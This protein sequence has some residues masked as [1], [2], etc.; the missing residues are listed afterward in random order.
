MRL[1]NENMNGDEREMNKITEKI[2]P[3]CKSVFKEGDEI[4][5]CSV[6]EMPHHK[7]CWIENQ[8]CATF[9]CNGT[10]DAP[11]FQPSGDAS[12]KTDFDAAEYIYCTKC[13]AQKFASDSFCYKCGHSIIQAP[14]RQTTRPQYAQTSDSNPYNQSQ[15]SYYSQHG[16]KSYGG[17]SNNYGYNQAGSFD[18]ELELLV[19]KNADYYVPKFIVMK[20]QNRKASW[21]WCSFL[22][23]PYWMIY[24]KMYGY[25]IA[26]LGGVF[27]VN[28]IKSWF[29]SFLLFIL[30]I[31]F[32]ILGNNIYMKYLEQKAEQ[33]RTLTGQYKT[34]FAAKNGGTNTSAVVLAILCFSILLT[35]FQLA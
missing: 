3:Y 33:M 16:D 25:G 20:T 1:F 17:Q 32:G 29:L 27:F 26:F 11:D 15:P 18:P 13:G 9:G 23:T 8:C 2:C 4:V 35:I 19:G 24:R 34:Y 10:I 5:K 12:S 30:D 31:I 21:N 22:F 7:D 14:P 6:C 28:I